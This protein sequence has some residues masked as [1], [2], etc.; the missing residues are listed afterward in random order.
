MTMRRCGRLSRRD[1]L[2][3]YPAQGYPAR[4][5]PARFLWRPRQGRANAMMAGG[6]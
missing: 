6:K 1:L 5:Y 2:C 3:D 4:G